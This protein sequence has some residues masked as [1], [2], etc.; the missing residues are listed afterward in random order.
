[1]KYKIE[2]IQKTI[3]ETTR[4]SMPIIEKKIQ[5]QLLQKQIEEDTRVSNNIKNFAIE[6]NRLNASLNI[7]LRAYINQRGQYF[8]NQITKSA[9]FKFFVDEPL[10]SKKNENYIHVFTSSES[11][12]YSLS[13]YEK[14]LAEIDSIYDV[15]SGNKALTNIKQLLT[16]ENSTKSPT[17]YKYIEKIIAQL[18]EKLIFSEF[19][20]TNYLKTFNAVY[21]QQVGELSADLEQYA[22]KL[23]DNKLK[24]ILSQNP[25]LE[26]YYQYIQEAATYET[27]WSQ[28][29]AECNAYKNQ[30]IDYDAAAR[31]HLWTMANPWNHKPE[32][33]ADVERCAR[34]F[35]MNGIPGQQS[36]LDEKANEE[37]KAYDAWKR[38]A[39]FAAD[40]A[41]AHHLS[42]DLTTLAGYQYNLESTLTAFI[43]AND[44]QSICTDIK[45]YCASK[46]RTEYAMVNQEDELEKSSVYSI[47]LKR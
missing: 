13:L 12:Q 5:A 19:N 31:D 34:D 35:M 29:V 3:K 18:R 16:Y 45:E 23:I 15:A 21:Q 47:Q 27:I 33:E 32:T 44:I 17:L 2:A 6:S 9:P 20:A 36:T 40:Y 42:K 37:R 24:E 7:L 4:E 38:H 28:K 25:A 11:D 39:D 43:P 46:I 14:L 10:K 22:D 41:K 8:A 30:P 1:M 26:R